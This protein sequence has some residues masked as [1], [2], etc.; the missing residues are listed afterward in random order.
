MVTD[1]QL[2]AN[3]VL[4]MKK[5]LIK[6]GLLCWKPGNKAIWIP[7]KKHPGRYIPISASQDI[8]EVADISCMDNGL[9]FLLVQCTGYE[10]GTNYSLMSERRKKFDNI[11]HH[12]PFGF[13]QPIVAGRIPGKKRWRL[14]FMIAFE[15][16]DT[17]EKDLIDIDRH[18]IKAQYEACR[19]IAFREHL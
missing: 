10:T 18:A 14:D 3:R 4:E 11:A 12:I 1:K 8:F 7:D 5:Q 19:I 13:V 16:W 17:I 2:G 6:C 9:P 15:K